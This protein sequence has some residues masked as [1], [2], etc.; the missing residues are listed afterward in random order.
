MKRI[1]LIDDDIEL[2]DWLLQTLQAEGFAV[3]AVHDGDQGLQQ[4]L[5]GGYALALLDDVM[6]SISGFQVLQGIRSRS[7]MP[8]VMMAGCG[9]D[10]ERIEALEMGADDYLPKPFNPRELIAR[11]RAI[12]RRTKPDSGETPV[13]RTPDLTIVGDIEID[14][15]M[16]LA[17]RQ[18]KPMELTSVEFNLL[19]ILLRAA[20]QVISRE[21]LAKGALGRALGMNDR[22]IDV[23][24]SSLRKKLGQRLSG[25][26]RIRTVRNWGYFY[27]RRHQPFEGKIKV[28]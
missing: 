18:G 25:V 21:E 19:E 17:Y 4:A 28:E 12:L 1:L 16:R 10:A 22:S 11:V 9:K 6:P 20:G 5:S 7:D 3:F 8:V 23:H 27:A 26:D 14:A 15:G 2:C 24:I 13:V